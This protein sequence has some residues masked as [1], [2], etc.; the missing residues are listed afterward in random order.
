MEISKRPAEEIE[1]ELTK[2]ESDNLKK[3]YNE[4]SITAGAD[5]IKQ[6][7]AFVLQ[8][9]DS[10]KKQLTEEQIKREDLINFWAALKN[11]SY[12]WNSQCSKRKYVKRFIRILFGKTKG[13]EMLSG[14]KGGEFKASERY[15]KDGNITNEELEKMLR[16]AS[17]LRDKAILTLLY[18]SAAR[19]EELLKLRW[20]DLK[21]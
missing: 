16:A 3:F 2:K 19:P 10:I 18:E 12:S 6:Y 17:S 9:K 20:R 4:I 5:K 15:T 11:S 21:I 8:F 7:R 13:E 1:K 14:L